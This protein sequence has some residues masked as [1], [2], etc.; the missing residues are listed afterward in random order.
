MRSRRRRDPKQPDREIRSEPGEPSPAPPVPATS[1]AE[2]RA[3]REA[4]A[5]MWVP[6]A[7]FTG[8]PGAK[9]SEVSFRGLDAGVYTR[10]LERVAPF[11]SPGLR[12][13]SDIRPSPQ[14]V[15]GRGAPQVMRSKIGDRVQL[16]LRIQGD[17][18]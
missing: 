8:P 15:L 6:G 12:H 14:A 3:L 17:R 11:S 10:L 13:V 1:S 5:W 9:P 4:A 7:S 18:T 16:G 2:A